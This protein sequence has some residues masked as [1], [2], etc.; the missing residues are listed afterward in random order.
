ML[1]LSRRVG[2]V[3]V[4]GDSILVQ[5]LKVDG[6]TVKMGVEAPKDV[7]IHRREVYERIAREDVIALDAQYDTH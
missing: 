4:I 6:R 2:E 1:T 5:V 7:T 3:I